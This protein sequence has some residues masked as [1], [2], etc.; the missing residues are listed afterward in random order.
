VG[1]GCDTSHLG[2]GEGYYPD[3][4]Y[5]HARDLADIDVW[6]Y[7]TAVP[8]LKGGARD[9][10]TPNPTTKPTPPVCVLYM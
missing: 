9:T 2:T 1:V 7:A 6:E 8:Q 10:P 4:G 3:G 5:G